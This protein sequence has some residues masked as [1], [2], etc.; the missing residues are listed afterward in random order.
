[1]DRAIDPAAAQQRR[2]RGVDDRVDRERGDVGDDD[3]QSRRANVDAEDRLSHAA[4]LPQAR[5]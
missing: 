3:L 5:A 2:V 4:I 1:M